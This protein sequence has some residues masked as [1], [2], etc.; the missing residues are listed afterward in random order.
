MAFT[1]TASASLETQPV[2]NARK[3]PLLGMGLSASLGEVQGA[4]VGLLSVQF[5]P[6]WAQSLHSG[7][8]C[9]PWCWCGSCQHRSCRFCQCHNWGPQCWGCPQSGLCIAGCF[10]ESIKPVIISVHAHIFIFTQKYTCNIYTRNNIMKLNTK[11]CHKP[12]PT[13]ISP[14]LEWVAVGYRT[15]ILTHK[16]FGI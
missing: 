8:S 13:F 10:L 12:N 2:W 4:H 9:S 16:N 5:T 11:Q 14:A 15:V 1:A 3:A 7:S 6:A